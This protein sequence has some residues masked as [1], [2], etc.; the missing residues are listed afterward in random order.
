[1]LK[2]T[3]NTSPGVESIANKIEN[4]TGLPL[5]LKTGMENLSGYALNDVKVHYNSPKPAQLRALAYTQGSNI[6]LGPK[7][8]RQLAHELGHVVQQ[9]RENIA[10]TFRMNGYNINDNPRFER[11]ADALG[12]AALRNTQTLGGGY[13]TE[14]STPN[15]APVIQRKIGFEF[16]VSS[17]IETYQSAEQG[18]YKSLN[19]KDKIINGTDF[20]VEADGLPA[21][22]TSWEFVTVPFPETKTG[23]KRLILAC[24]HM[25]YIV[26]A[27][28]KSP[29][30]TP[31]KV[32]R[33]LIGEHGNPVNDRYFHK[34]YMDPLM[35]KP[36]VTA[37]F[38]LSALDSMYK[39]VSTS[40]TSNNNPNLVR[41]IGNLQNDNN[42]EKSAHSHDSGLG[43]MRKCA[44][45]A[46]NRMGLNV[47]GSTTELRAL[48]TYLMQ[49]IVGGNSNI[50]ATPKT[51]M[52]L[53][54]AR[55]D[56]A[57]T[58]NILPPQFITHFRADPN[59]FV[60]LVMSASN[61]FNGARLAENKP[62][63]GKK[64]FTNLM[65]SIDPRSNMKSPFK[66][67]SRRQW[68]R[69]LV[70]GTDLL[71][72]GNYPVRDNWF[73]SG[74][75][76]TDLKANQLLDSMG[77]LGNRLDPGNRPIFEIRSSKSIF[78]G[79][80]TPYALDFFNYVLFLHDQQNRAESNY[81]TNTS[82]EDKKR[83]ILFDKERG[84]MR[85]RYTRDALS[86]NNRLP[87]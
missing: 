45:K 1:K 12:N 19:K 18:G 52:Q 72:A 43:N 53:V 33:T 73:T 48:V 5:N 31:V 75:N 68:L 67:V 6:Y 10:P 24:N 57:A 11:E 7:Q 76:K 41:D 16:E 2:E 83:L 21:G 34:T 51:V 71:S 55:T 26:E 79:L 82:Y 40:V 47:I 56:L 23:L 77:Q 42:V 70:N 61:E 14:K 87:R 32:N 44:D 80:M 15:G 62:V 58:F 50:T 36:Q 22:R 35:V 8:E 25:E 4:K 63:I 60:Q 37:G 20:Y 85:Y 30:Q 59:R 81:F 54:L 74:Q 39:L 65:Y 28:Q 64:L 27:L 69:G 29:I 86:R 9:K 3:M 46:I 38:S 13:K 84:D 66:K 17:N 49:M 78:A